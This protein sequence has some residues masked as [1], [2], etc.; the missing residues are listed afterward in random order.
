M[1]HSENNLKS[2]FSNSLFFSDQL[3]NPSTEFLVFFDAEFWIL[4]CVSRNSIVSSSRLSILFHNIFF[5]SFLVPSFMY[6]VT[7]KFI[8]FIFSIILQLSNILQGLICCFCWILVLVD[9]FFLFSKFGVAESFS[10]GLCRN[11]VKP[12]LKA[13]FSRKILY[14]LPPGAQGYH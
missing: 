1:L 7:F 4:F 2:P 9:C 5:L 13:S 10:V 11:S 8:H 3:L 6:L 12:G 14:L